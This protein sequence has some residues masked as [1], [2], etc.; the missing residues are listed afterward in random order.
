[1]IQKQNKSKRH[2]FLSGLILAEFRISIF[3]SRIQIFNSAYEASQALKNKQVLVNGKKISKNYLLKKGDIIS[4]LKFPTNSKSF[5]S[6]SKRLSP[7]YEYDYY[8]NTFVILFD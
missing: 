3:L 1:M 2:L 6:Y 4:I 7:F 5:F 8:T